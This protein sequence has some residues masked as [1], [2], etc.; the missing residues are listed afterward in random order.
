MVASL[1]GSGLTEEQEVCFE[2]VEWFW[3]PAVQSDC[4]GGNPDS[5]TYQLW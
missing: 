4:L 5:P 2:A 1:I 3:P